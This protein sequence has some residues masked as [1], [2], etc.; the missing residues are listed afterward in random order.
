MNRALAVLLLAR[1][2]LG[3]LYAAVTPPFEASDEITHYPVVRYIAAT[4]TLPVQDPAQETRWKQEGS[5]PPLYYAIGALLTGWID[6]ADYEANAVLNPFAQV[7]IPGTTHNVNHVAH[8]PG[9]SLW[10]GGTVLA[11]YLIR[12][13][14]A[15]MGVAAVYFTYRLA[16]EAAPRR[17][18]VALL[19][20]ALVAFNPMVLFINASVNNDTLVMLLAAAALWL[21]ARD[22]NDASP[23]P[24]WRRTVAL[25]VIAGLAALTKVSG[26]ALIPVIALAVTFAAWRLRDWRSWWLRG[27]AL[28]VIVLALAGWWY[29]RNYLLYGELLG[30][31]RMSQIAGPR[32]AGFGLADL[33]PE[34]GSF[35]RAGWGVFGAFDILAPAWFFTL[36][37]AF[38]ALALGGLAMLAG[39]RLL[40]R[41]LPRNWPLHF[42]FLT[43]LVISFAGLVRW[44]LLTMGSQGRLLFGAGSVIAFYLALGFLAWLPRQWQTLAA[45]IPTAGLALCAAGIAAFTIAPAY[46]PPQPVTALPADALPLDIWFGNDIHLVGYRADRQTTVAGESL[47]VTL[48]WTTPAAITAN[49][50]AALNVYG[51]RGENV[52]KI[53][54]WPGAGLL[55]TSYWRPGVIYP[56]SY[57]FAT[58]ADAD[59]PTPITL[60]IGFWQ[61]SMDDWLPIRKN[62]APVDVIFLPVGDL[63]SPTRAPAQNATT[64]IATFEQGVSLDSYHIETTA[65]EL[66]VS[67]SWR[68]GGP[69]PADYKTFIHL[70]DNQG[71][72]VAQG[73]A[74]PRDGVWPTS[75]WRAGE[76]VPSSYRLALP[77][78]LPAAGYSLLVGMYA[79][80]SGERLAA[81]QPDG[82]E[83]PN[84]AV[85]LGPVQLP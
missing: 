79:P 26:A 62:G 49:L 36:V 10:Q 30:L 3:L 27:F 15:L 39:R 74:P 68:G 54:A 19:A 53:D 1:F 41:R 75:K 32:P 56:D 73:D 29:A 22:L 60:N 42:I 55:P 77:T 40:R 12:W 38:S 85:T 66:N 57:L 13:L 46:R 84:R 71:N 44:S 20:A 64:P 23:G 6:T 17:P 78:N 4:R 24:R 76:S 48:Y 9:Q 72:V 25:G 11:I 33:I 47:P 50:N 34:W 43:F 83:W 16:A 5:Q 28:S 63:V 52:A 7:G 31:Q 80:E 61:G 14:S 2:L 21:V 58:P 81:Y 8:P 37:V 45:A 59:A 67:L 35:W 18:A 69:L 70:I 82:S 51:F 65:G